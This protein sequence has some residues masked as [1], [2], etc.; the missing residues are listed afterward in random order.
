MKYL[1]I[2]KEHMFLNKKK[3]Y[4][5]F[6]LKYHLLLALN[7]NYSNKQLQAIETLEPLT[8][9]K[10]QDLESLLDIHLSL[11][12]FYFQ[13][14][15]FKKAHTIFSKFNHTDIWYTDKAGKEWVIKKNLIEILLN[16]ELE[17]I[18]L[19]ESR[20]L[21]FKRTYNKYLKDI[22]QERVIIFLKL[23]EYYYKNPDKVTSIKY[24]NIVED[25]FEWTTNQREDIFVMSFYSWL[26]GKMNKT[27]L[28]KTTLQLIK[29]VS[30]E[31]TN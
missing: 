2:M 4:N 16:I 30:H 15:D 22:K 7:L 12:V 28:Y 17:N 23:V 1:E 25:S 19:V 9:H 18:A 21:S 24:K 14:N 10:N 26:K 27:D 13:K 3:H 8:K 6:K 31:T 5:V 29:Q 20:L 11:I